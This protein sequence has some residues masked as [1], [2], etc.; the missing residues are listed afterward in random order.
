MTIKRIVLTCLLAAIASSLAAQQ[1]EIPDWENSV[2]FKLVASQNPIRPGDAFQVALVA[3]IV[4]GYHLYGPEEAY[5]SR[6]ELEVSGEG[7]E[8]GDPVYPPVEKREL[9]GLGT[10]DLYEGEIA[11]AVPLTL[12]ATAKSDEHTVKAMV[13]YQVCTDFACSAPTSDELT[14]TVTGGGPDVDVQQQHPEIFKPE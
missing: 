11:I 14:L 13:S 3:E 8:A 12:S 9:S 7:L 6:T 1:F 4:E 5:P 2:K 10:Y